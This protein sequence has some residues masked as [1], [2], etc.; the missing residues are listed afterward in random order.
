MRIRVT[1]PEAFQS[2]TCTCK[3]ASNRHFEALLSFSIISL[4]DS[5]KIGAL[6]RYYCCDTFADLDEKV[7]R[8]SS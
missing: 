4:V 2:R 7:L 3:Q 5:T 1:V 8:T 6:K